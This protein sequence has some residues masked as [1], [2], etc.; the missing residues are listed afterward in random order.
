MRHTRQAALSIA[1]LALLASACGKNDLAAPKELCGVPLK[2]STTSPLIP[3]GEELK[4]WEPKPIDTNPAYCY[5]KVDG[6][7]I[8][9]ITVWLFDGQPRPE[10]WAY[11][12]SEYKLGALR[13]TPFAGTSVIGSDGAL[14]SAKC[15]GPDKY[16]QFKIRFSGDRVEDSPAGVEKLQHF[17]EDFVTGAKKKIGCTA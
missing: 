14:V 15:D 13:K 6:I 5:I 4:T 9:D 17:V 3:Q 12:K 1:A 8:M 7:R 16:A 2:E 11:A 10:D